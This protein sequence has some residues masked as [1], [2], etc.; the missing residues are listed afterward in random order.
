MSFFVTS[1]ALGCP[2]PCAQCGYNFDD[3]NVDENDGGDCSSG[4]G[5]LGGLVGAD[6]HCQKLATAAGFGG[7]VWR[8]Y[9]S[10]K[11]G[12]GTSVH[13]RD[14][15]GKGPWYNAAGVLIATNLTMLH[16]IDPNGTFGLA[17]N[18]ISQST[19]LTEQGKLL[20][21]LVLKPNGGDHDIL[22]GS[23]AD[24]TAHNSNC[25]NWTS[26]GHNV[27]GQV[28]HHDLDGLLGPGSP[29][30]SWNAAHDTRCSAAG[31]DSTAGAGYFYCFAAD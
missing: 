24:G 27:Y 3:N 28:G 15:I 18:K 11:S 7:R 5:N 30:R 23:K 9:L 21:G 16:A 8:A 19:A 13:A 1:E 22:T 6:A 26:S 17:L 14:R 2:S 10:T 20:A 29:G 12:P 4:S 31:M 25:N